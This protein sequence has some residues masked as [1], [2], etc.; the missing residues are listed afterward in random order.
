MMHGQVASI[1]YAF[2]HKADVDAAEDILRR[3]V[4]GNWTLY[5]DGRSG[6]LKTWHLLDESGQEKFYAVLSLNEGTY[7]L[8]VST[9]EFGQH[10]DQQ[11]R[12]NINNL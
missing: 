9:N 11:N 7:V 5:D 3:N 8:Q 2:E 4:P 10:L 12:S 1:C 6:T